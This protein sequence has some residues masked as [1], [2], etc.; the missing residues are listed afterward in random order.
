M[1]KILYDFMQQETFGHTEIN[2][3]LK[4]QK[5]K[6]FVSPLRK[7][8][9]QLTQLYPYLRFKFGSFC[10]NVLS[11]SFLCGRCQ[12]MCNSKIMIQ[13]SIAAHSSKLHSYTLNQFDILQ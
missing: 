1:Y 11:N 3:P 2:N 5:S 7:K 12:S 8:K 13:N 10:K 4:N 9:C 6:T